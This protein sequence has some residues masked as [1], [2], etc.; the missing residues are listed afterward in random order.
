MLF[1]DGLAGTGQVWQYELGECMW[2]RLKT[3]YPTRR[4]NDPKKSMDDD[5]CVSP[6]T[7]ALRCGPE[8]GCVHHWSKE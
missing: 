5:V 3:E 4:P 7:S 2:P 1:R 8:F 6:G